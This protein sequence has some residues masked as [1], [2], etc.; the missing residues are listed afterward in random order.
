MT[1][2]RAMAL[3]VGLALV[4]PVL[5]FLFNNVSWPSRGS[6]ADFAQRL[7][8]AR[9][10][11]RDWA[12]GRDDALIEEVQARWSDLRN[13]ALLHMLVDAGE[14]AGEDNLKQLALAIQSTAPGGWWS[15]MVDPRFA[16]PPPA[17][18]V[19]LQ[20]YQQWILHGLGCDQLPIAPEAQRRLLLPD[21]YRTGR[22]THQLLALYFYGRYC[23][24]G[25]I[26]DQARA[27]MPRLAE[28]IAQEAAL[29]FRL[30]DLYLQRIVCLLLAGRI[31]LVRPRWVERVLAA[32][33]TNGGWK[34]S[35]Y[36][37]DSRIFRF[38]LARQPTSAHATAQ[39]LWLTSLIKYRHPE[40]IAQH[41]R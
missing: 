6:R 40:W 20:E 34:Y 7:D 28:R 36:G 37:W 21:A 33:Q 25:P 26:A 18:L 5:A 10:A 1:K 11:S 29:D 9:G 41:Y 30:T 3:V 23:A 27:L 12:L 15:R 19:G 8:R 35:W 31:D 17:A 39:G 24:N 14:M 32:Q 22:L 2:K 16:A 13:P 4:L 38:H